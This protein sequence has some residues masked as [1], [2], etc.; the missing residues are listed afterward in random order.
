MSVTDEVEVERRAA[1]HKRGLTPVSVLTGLHKSCALPH[2]NFTYKCLEI[3]LRFVSRPISQ[4]QPFASVHDYCGP[5]FSPEPAPLSLV[6]MR[7][8]SSP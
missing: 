4:S 1:A 3:S 5:R 8:T 7:G 6:N 2:G